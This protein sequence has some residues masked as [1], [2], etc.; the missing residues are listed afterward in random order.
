MSPLTAT[1]RSLEVKT[2][3]ASVLTERMIEGIAK[4]ARHAKRESDQLWLQNQIKNHHKLLLAAPTQTRPKAPAPMAESK[5]RSKAFRQRL[6]YWQAKGFSPDEAHRRAMITEQ[7]SLPPAGDGVLPMAPPLGPGRESK[8]FR[9]RLAYWHAK[10]LSPE[11]AHRRAS[12]KELFSLERTTSMIGQPMASPAETTAGKRSTETSLPSAGRE[13]M[14]RS[15]AA[16]PHP[17]ATRRHFDQVPSTPARS[18]E[19]T[20]KLDVVP[21]WKP[22]ADRQAGFHLEAGGF[23]WDVIIPETSLRSALEAMNS[24]KGRWVAVVRGCLGERT[25]Q[26][27]ALDNAA[28]SVF[29]KTS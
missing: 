26:G 3:G 24:G 11:E 23:L 8:A 17:V 6:A 7:L 13:S 28:I 16:V 9:Q 10:G 1:I 27:F 14:A 2:L 22:L 20:L 12:I 21:I 15:A 25:P 29:V 19:V 4:Q 18:I 5:R